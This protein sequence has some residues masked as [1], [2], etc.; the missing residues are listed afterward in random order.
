MPGTTIAFGAVLCA[1]GLWG[2]FGAAPEKQSVTALI[3]FFFGDLL[4]LCGALAFNSAW[5]KHAMHAAAGVALLG[6]LMAGGRAAMTIAKSGLGQML[7]D[8]PAIGR[9]PRMVMAM[10]IVCLVFV[11]IC[12]NSFLSARRRRKAEAAG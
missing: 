5:R 4:I 1:I 6:F 2:Y 3:P 9:A 8:D 10:A 11:I 7:S 12:V